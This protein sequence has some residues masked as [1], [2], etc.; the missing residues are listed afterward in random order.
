V[1]AEPETE[2]VTDA[3]AEP[4]TAWLRRWPTWAGIGAA[5]AAVA[6]LVGLVFTLFPGLRPDPGDTFG[7]KVAVVR[8]E[9]GVTADEWLRRTTFSPTAYRQRRAEFLR[10]PS[11]SQP[12]PESARGNLRLRGRIAYVSSALEGFKGESVAVRWSLYDARSKQRLDRFTNVVAGRIKGDAPSDRTE[13]EVWLP[14]APGRG[15][16]FVRVD[17]YD[18][19]DNLLD[20]TDSTAFRGP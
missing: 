14:P 2:A 3:S 12:D 15:P 20:S 5:I 10:G 17:L 7:A 19:R 6:G 11:G 8:V 18:D 1:C 16:Y 13:L 4:A 9:P